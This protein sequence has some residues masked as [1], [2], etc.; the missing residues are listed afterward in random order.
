MSAAVLAGRAWI[1]CMLLPAVSGARAVV[2]SHSVA[3]TCACAFTWTVLCSLHAHM[4]ACPL[5]TLVVPLGVTVLSLK[6]TE[7]LVAPSL[8]L[9]GTMDWCAR[10]PMVGSFW[11]ELT[12]PRV[13]PHTH[14]SCCCSVGRGPAAGSESLLGA[15][16][17]FCSPRGSPQVLVP[18]DPPWPPFLAGVG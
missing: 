17:G 10:L 15:F 1:A 5:L 12:G 3:E 16:G 9:G 6:L 11:P 2:A 8:H 18:S 4:H 7:V 13:T 14:C